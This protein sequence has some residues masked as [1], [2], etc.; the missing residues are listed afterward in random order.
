MP[1]T[2][3]TVCRSLLRALTRT[4]GSARRNRISLGIDSL[5]DRWV[6][7]A[8][9][10]GITNGAGE[11]PTLLTTPVPAN[12]RT[13]HLYFLFGIDDGAFNFK[14]Q[15][16]SGGSAATI[17]YNSGYLPTKQALEFGLTS[18]Y[19]AVPNKSG[20]G[21]PLT[22]DTVALSI[23]ATNIYDSTIKTTVKQL[24]TPSYLTLQPRNGAGTLA[25]EGFSTDIYDGTGAIPF[26][27]LT[28][29][30]P[31]GGS[32]LNADMDPVRDGVQVQAEANG[33][34]S[35]E[36]ERPFVKSDK[37]LLVKVTDPLHPK[38]T[39]T[40]KQAYTGTPLTVIRE[41]G[42]P[43]TTK[44]GADG[45]TIDTYQG[46]G[47]T[48]NGQ[49]AIKPPKGAVVTDSSGTPI[50][51]GFVTAD[52]E[53]GFIFYLKR[54]VGTLYQ[55]ASQAPIKV[56]NLTA[57][58]YVTILQ[59]YLPLVRLDF[60]PAPIVGN[61][62]PTAAGH[63]TVALKKY[64]SNSYGWKSTT[65][66]AAVNTAGADA[67]GVP[68]DKLPI[69]N[70]GVKGAGTSTFSVAVPLTFPLGSLVPV[71]VFAS[72]A[73]TAGGEAVAFTITAEGA[74][75][76]AVT[77]GGGSFGAF[78]QYNFAAKDGNGDGK[79]DFTFALVAPAVNPNQFW[80]VNGIVVNYY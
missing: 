77:P 30:A 79:I 75:P 27:L 69:F 24:Y 42:T 58:N 62:S 78:G 80:V 4:P 7:A 26:G 15:T 65:G 1:R 37:T 23:T 67:A 17:W 21:G 36:I 59:S 12:G 11:S 35:V 10:I 61:P 19:M 43:L 2:L 48:P 22:P 74:P 63:T 66:L 40:Y 57:K 72:T 41:D 31:A 13:Q 49:V 6:P 50:L 29:T 53:G 32:V 33:N 60:E 44:V 51:G 25:G 3:A 76:Q 46:G 47:A 18:P 34:F 14:M 45:E 20:T 52:E 56:T 55:K 5:E 8:N 39:V 54:P 68:A 73:D 28:V 38:A 64:A 71:N 16:P 70:D 9:L